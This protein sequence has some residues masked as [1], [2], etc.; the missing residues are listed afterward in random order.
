MRSEDIK[1]IRRMRKNGT[2]LAEISRLLGYT[3]PQ[4]E[5]ACN[6]SKQ[7]TNPQDP[8]PEEIER[9]KAVFRAKH[10]EAL[11]SSSYTP[12]YIPGIKECKIK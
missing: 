9:A 6:T 8:T 2:K 4:I 7:E 5:F 10:L 11:R 1:R 3:I 12:T